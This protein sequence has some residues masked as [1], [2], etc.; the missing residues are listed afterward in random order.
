MVF[1]IWVMDSAN[2][3]RTA[4]AAR[5]LVAVAFACALA[6]CPRV[7]FADVEASGNDVVDNFAASAATS[8]VADETGEDESLI[9]ADDPGPSADGENAD[10]PNDAVDPAD[11]SDSPNSVDPGDSVDSGDPG[12][13][14]D[15]SASETTSASETPADVPDDGKAVSGNDENERDIAGSRNDFAVY[16]FGEAGTEARMLGVDEPSD[17]RAIGHADHADDEAPSGEESQAREKPSTI[18]TASDTRQAKTPRKSHAVATSTHSSA[19]ASS[20]ASCIDESAYQDNSEGLDLAS[21]SDDE[22]L[23]PKRPTSPQPP[24]PASPAPPA[25]PG[26][27]VAPASISPGGNDAG[28]V[29]QLGDAAITPDSASLHTQ[30]LSLRARGFVS[31]RELPRHGGYLRCRSPSMS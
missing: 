27:P 17:V 22:P 2:R 26:G 29:Q 16:Q 13:P 31:K 15:S 10:V 14:G 11:P 20:E 8:A 23:A 4:F 6:W 12:E 28:S 24:T 21:G 7:A 30:R 25:E 1:G 19:T 5:V 9:I 18:A 3:H